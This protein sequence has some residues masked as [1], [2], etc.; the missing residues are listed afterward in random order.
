MALEKRGVMTVTICTDHFAIMASAAM[1]GANMPA[2]VE[3]GLVLIPHPL[4]ELRPA[5]LAERAAQIVPQVERMLCLQPL[6][7]GARV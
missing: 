6:P 3:Q 2:L 4:A 5:Q 7:E 1:R